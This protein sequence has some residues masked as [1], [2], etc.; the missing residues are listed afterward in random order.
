MSIK[1][2]VDRR[3]A[4]RLLG[5]ELRGRVGQRPFIIALPRGG[6]P[7]GFEVAAA[8]GAPLDVW[9]VRKVGVPWQPE[10]GMGAVAEGGYVHLSPEI[11][12]QTGLTQPELER[13]VWE[14]GREVEARVRLFRGDRP[15]PG[16][17]DRNVIIVDDGI[18]TGGTVA[19]AIAAIRREDPLTLIVAAP[20][21]A[22]DTVLRISRVA[23][24]VTCLITPRH[25]NAIGDW[26][27]DFT[28]VED[29]EV[30]ALLR[31]AAQ[32]LGRVAQASAPSSDEPE[33]T[34]AAFP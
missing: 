13:L 31:S 11:V 7:V 3:A 29:S 28:Q 34:D 18:A 14:K 16:L 21:A 32:G 10:L 33:P 2:F 26:Y 9:V 15:R 24:D 17:R 4:G 23:D 8:L 19:A 5:A 1:R 22:E 6:V 25:L 30:A 12:R 20:V 27:D